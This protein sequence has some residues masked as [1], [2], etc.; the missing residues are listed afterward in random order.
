MKFIVTQTGARRGYAVPRILEQ[1]GLLERFYT[2]YCG[3]KGIGAML[4]PL[5]F[6]PVIGK[7]LGRVKNRVIPNSIHEK[8]STFS[9]PVIQKFLRS[10]ATDRSPEQAFRQSLDFCKRWGKAMINAGFGNATHVYSM[11]GEAG[12]FVSEAFHRGL[13]V[14]SEVYILISTD[15]IM[16]KE[17]RDFPDWESEV[18]DYE[19]IRREILD[20]DV[21][22]DRSHFFICPSQA[23]KDD[24]V[25]NWHVNSEC[26]AVVPYGMNARWLEL[27]PEPT[28]G[29]VLFVGT[30]GLRKGIHYLAMAA[31]ILNSL[32][33]NYEFRIAG[34]VSDQ[35]RNHPQCQRL[36]F[37]GRIP[38][39]LI[40]EEF[41]KADVFALP[42][43]A[44]GSAEVTY[45][46]LGASIPLVVTAAAGSVA[47]NNIE[48]LVVPERDPQ[49][50]ANALATII[51]NRD[52]RN[53]MAFA[54]RERARE[55]TW[56]K[57]G[58]RLISTLRKVVN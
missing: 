44:E 4:R 24:L 8:T 35:V 53:K 27:A 12:P 17:R 33:H 43:L 55:F 51:E 25:D 16:L 3:S 21:L 31:E 23:V 26:T 45:E 5:Q 22:L 36:N 9:G 41:R 19:S 49:A 37:L 20:D 56:E 18:P 47:R 10:A 29:R 15:R 48:G 1:A 11:L 58:G 2:D 46:A 52:T 50:L 38:R 34:D 28:H 14:V 30:A 6:V 7:R 42:S 40:H 57:Y 39:N 54:A 32:G 13:T